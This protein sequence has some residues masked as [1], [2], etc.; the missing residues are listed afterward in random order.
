MLVV[1][2][3]VARAAAVYALSSDIPAERGFVDEARAPDGTSFR[4]MGPHVVTYAPRQ[5]GYFTMTLRPPDRPLQRP[6]EVEVRIGGSIVDRRTL[7]PGQWQTVLI[8]VE[9][10]ATTRFR[11]IDVRATPVWMD[12]RKLAQRTSEVDVAVTA[13]VSEMRWIGPGR[14]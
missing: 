5:R 9:E 6:M 1:A 14:R 10:V 12:T 7:V 8:P 11:R 2:A 3:G 13:M 4:W